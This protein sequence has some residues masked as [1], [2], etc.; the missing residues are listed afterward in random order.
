MD[1]VGIIYKLKP[2]NLVF[3]QCR[4][5]FY[6][7]TYGDA[8]FFKHWGNNKGPNGRYKYVTLENPCNNH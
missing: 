8:S 5:K 6:S 7:K 4:K 1:Q 3:L 2:E